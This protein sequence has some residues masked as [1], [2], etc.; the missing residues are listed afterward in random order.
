MGTGVYQLFFHCATIHPDLTVAIQK[1]L[2]VFLLF[3]KYPKSIPQE[4]ASCLS[5]EGNVDLQKAK[6]VGLPLHPQG[7]NPTHMCILCIYCQL[8]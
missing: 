3:K 6:I 1:I 8:I 5:L 4:L 2:R 7:N